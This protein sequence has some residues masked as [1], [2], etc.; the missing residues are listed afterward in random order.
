MHYWGDDWFKK[1]GDQLYDAIDYIED[2]LRKNGIFVYGKEKYGTYRD[3]YLG[4]WNGSLYDLLFRGRLYIGSS[5]KSKYNFIAKIQQFIHEYIYWCID[6]GWSLRMLFEKDSDKRYALIKKHLSGKEKG[7]AQ[8]IRKRKWYGKYVEKK[9][10]IVN[11]VFQD[12][13]KKYPDVVEELIVDIDHWEWIVPGKY[14]NVSG[15][16]IHKKYWKPVK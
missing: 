9:K 16:E 3:E 12:A 5:H 10:N 13:C 4:F 14:G 6:N 11:K 1:Y 2:N 7:L 8:F 15:E